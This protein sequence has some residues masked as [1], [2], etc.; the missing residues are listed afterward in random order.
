MTDLAKSET[1]IIEGLLIGDEEIFETLVNVYYPA[2][3]RLARIYVPEDV[4]GDVVQETWIAVL[5]GLPHFERRSSLKTWIFSILMNRARSHARSEYRHTQHSSLDDWDE[6]SVD[7]DRFLPDDHPQYPQH[8][9]DSPL[10]W[11]ESVENRLISKETLD[12]IGEIIEELPHSQREVILLRDFQH[13][14]ADEVC[15]LLSL[16]EANQRVLLH[17][18]RS[19]IRQSLE[20]YLKV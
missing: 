13:W 7:G 4:A 3:I 18:A 12:M 1:Q 14:S 6:P 2:M 8:W 17:R 20:S 10:Q 9:K 16:T 19:K 15:Q 5:K 11:D